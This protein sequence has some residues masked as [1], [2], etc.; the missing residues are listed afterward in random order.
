[1]I[2]FL[3]QRPVSVYLT[4]L[5]FIVAGIW[6]LKEISVTMLPH[7]DIPEILIIIEEPGIPA[8]VLE[9]EYVSVIREGIS[10]IKNLVDIRSETENGYA[11]IFLV[12]K[13]GVN[14]DRLVVMVNERI[15]RLME[16]FPRGFK[17]PRIINTSL[18]DIPVLFVNVY[19]SDTNQFPLWLEL[20]QYAGR[21]IWKRLEQ[22]PQV[23]F[24]E[25][26]G[27]EKTRLNIAIDLKKLELYG[28]DIQQIV[29]SLTP[30]NEE[31]ISVD[32]R[33]GNYK[34]LLT[35]D[36]QEPGSCRPG[37]VSIPVSSGYSV[38][39][40][41]IADVRLVSYPDPGSCY[42]N[43]H[44]CISFAIYQRHNTSLAEL[45]RQVVHTMEL[46]GKDEPLME[47]T[48]TRDR[49]LNLQS[50]LNGLSNSLMSG[51]FLAVLILL[52]TFRDIRSVFIISITIPLAMVLSVIGIY[53]AGISFNIISISGLVLAIGMMTDT[54]LIIIDN[55]RQ[56]AL[57]FTS[58]NDTIIFG[59]GEVIRPMIT[60]AFTTFAVFIPLL[61]ISDT[62]REFFNEQAITITIGIL[63]S[64]IVGIF[65]I[66]VLCKS[67]YRER[68]NFFSDAHGSLIAAKY[69]R[70][71]EIVMKRSWMSLIGFTLLL[72]LG[73]LLYL[74]LDKEAFPEYTKREYLCSIEW[75]EN[76]SLKENE[77]R[78]K[79]ILNSIS[80]KGYSITA[81]CGQQKL[82]D[83]KEM[84][85]D[86]NS[87]LMVISIDDHEKNSK[88]VDEIQNSLASFIP[89]PEFRIW[90]SQNLFSR[91]FVQ[92]N[93]QVVAR[94]DISGF[95]TP[96]D[97]TS[98]SNKLL[99]DPVF[100]LPELKS[101][102][103]VMV[104]EI[105]ENMAHRLQVPR[106]KVL[107]EI[108]FFREGI[109]LDNVANQDFKGVLTVH[110]RARN[111]FLKSR[112]VENDNGIR[113]PLVLLVDSV[114]KERKD[115]IISDRFG[116]VMELPV[117]TNGGD[118]QEVVRKIQDIGKDNNLQIRTT[119]NYFQ[120]R[121]LMN[122]IAHSLFYSVILLYL[123]MAAQFE[124]FLQPLII[125]IEILID[126][127]GVFLLHII[128][129]IDLNMVSGIGIIVMAGIII[130]DSILK[131]DTINRE[132]RSGKGLLEAIRI[133]GRRRFNP[134]ILTSL[135]TVLA[136]LPVL[137]TGGLGSSLQ[138]P[139]AISV[140]GGLLTGTIASLFFIPVAYF[141]LEY[142]LHL[143]RRK[144]TTLNPS[145][146]NSSLFP[147][148]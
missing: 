27:N 31:I 36:F 146:T 94:I 48:I 4:G 43:Q 86:Q 81:Y 9:N 22:I 101:E 136:L 35:I 137:F 126:L 56:Q 54:S 112:F 116:A 57:R 60:A 120:G 33:R 72:P 63:A 50:A 123:I 122:E 142:L 26:T 14:K 44:K 130:N 37:E 132:R 51:I 147:D 121:K 80:L 6:C 7:S 30:Y 143:I 92:N 47:Y 40:K 20:G 111:G 64:L 96:E 58:I 18:S 8:I 52:I 75:S 66:P 135:T 46:S 2:R 95:K 97:F 118:V 28:I 104:L 3:I 71:L 59:T 85:Q 76:I 89:V 79:K 99:K 1:M 25:M 88:I 32:V 11:R 23:S 67:L 131:V 24:V 90:P 144:V 107:D 38:K 21:V 19:L 55:I 114:Y 110:E 127:A 42:N 133:G 78:L 134:I 93:E 62:A 91:V 53:L 13:Q 98:F 103:T 45:K 70:A 65:L 109:N 138:R 49:S 139:L 124:S 128:A 12:M 17:R 39:L 100:I 84:P 87:S 83:D 141:R 140:I 69:E 77:A 148:D 129:G 74:Y 108:A 105:D 113:I 145:K 15:D 102:S 29:K 117:V 115:K 119:G 125:L 41:E 61:L 16:Q 10:T 73:Y 68:N 34:Y 82:L 106:E 5:C